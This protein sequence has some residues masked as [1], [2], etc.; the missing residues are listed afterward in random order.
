MIADEMLAVRGTTQ[1]PDPRRDGE[2]F[3]IRIAVE[4]EPQNAPLPPPRDPHP[5]AELLHP[6]KRRHAAWVHTMVQRMHSLE[7]AEAATGAHRGIPKPRLGQEAGRHQA[8][9][10]AGPGI[11]G[12][13]VGQVHRPAGQ[14][15][16]ALRSSADG[17]MPQVVAGLLLQQEGDPQARRAEKPR[18][19]QP[20]ES[21]RMPHQWMSGVRRRAHWIMHDGT[22]LVRGRQA[23][24][25]RPAKRSQRPNDS[26]RVT[27]RL[28]TPTRANWLHMDST[29][30]TRLHRRAC[31]PY[32]T[33]TPARGRRRKDRSTRIVSRETMPGSTSSIPMSAI[34]GVAE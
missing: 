24:R 7:N 9:G 21:R 23:V 25:S 27:T 19:I 32:G 17:G 26:G 22:T 18:R 12:R 13:Q 34:R 2:C 15:A 30:A 33:M 28:M 29:T 20:Q 5:G 10:R 14:D 31:T 16:G 3:H 8:T 11:A 6:A 4:R 1:R